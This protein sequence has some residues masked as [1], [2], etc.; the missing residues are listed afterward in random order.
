MTVK[1]EVMKKQLSRTVP[2]TLFLLDVFFS[3]YI[4]LE[5]PP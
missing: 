4:N 5:V 1:T 2:L 3:R